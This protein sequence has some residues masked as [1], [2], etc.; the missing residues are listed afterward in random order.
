[1]CNVLLYVIIIVAYVFW[2]SNSCRVTLKS[3]N[4][5]H[6]LDHPSRISLRP[7]VRCNWFPNPIFLSHNRFN[8]RPLLKICQHV[9]LTSC[10]TL[11]SNKSDWIENVNLHKISY[12]AALPHSHTHKH[13]YIFEGTSR[14]CTYMNTR[15]KLKLFISIFQ[16]M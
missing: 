15:S 12:K 1:M 5:L 4:L 9:F 14:Y 6:V 16:V 10:C 7:A 2:N 8:Q 3:I 13:R 11:A